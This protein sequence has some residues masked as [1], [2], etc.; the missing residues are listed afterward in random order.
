M[1]VEKAGD[2]DRREIAKLAEVLR[3]SGARVVGAI[4]L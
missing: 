1:L 4:V 3:I 2:S